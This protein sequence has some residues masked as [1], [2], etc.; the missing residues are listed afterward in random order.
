MTSLRLYDRVWIFLVYAI[1]ASASVNGFYSKW[2]SIIRPDTYQQSSARIDFMLDGTL[3]RPYVYRRLLPD[4]ANFADRVVPP[5]WK[6]W[7][8]AQRPSSPRPV[9]SVLAT[10]F[11]P[12][13]SVAA[14]KAYAFRFLV[15]YLSTCLFVLLALYA[16]C[17]ICAE[18]SFPLLSSIFAPLLV[19][20]LM[21]YTMNMG[22]YFYDYSELAML[23]LAAWMALRFKWWW[24]LPIPVLA[25]W[26]KE[27]FLLFIPTLSPFFRQR[28][29]R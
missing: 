16:M 26:N 19:L 9:S 12:D 8:V 24:L 4:S 6:S 15:V 25:T 23:A 7:F 17:W 14:Y 2:E 5:A 22:G 3:S 29:S 21:P 13:S 28:S 18:L 10:N 1:T 20:L 27:S 11:D